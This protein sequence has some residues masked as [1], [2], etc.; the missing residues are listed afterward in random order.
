[1]P[2]TNKFAFTIPDLAWLALLGL[3]LVLMLV[4]PMAGIYQSFNSDHPYP[5]AFLKFMLLAPMG[6][7]LAARIRSGQWKKPTYL[8]GRA[9]VWGFLGMMIALAFQLFSG[10]AAAAAERGFLPRSTSALLNAFIISTA[11]N[12][13]FAP[14]MMAFHR[15]TDTWFDLKTGGTPRPTV[16][17]VAAAVAWDNF[18]SFVVLKTIPFFW[19]PAHTLTF[20]LPGEYRVLMAAMLSMALG[21]LL[22]FAKPRA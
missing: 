10:G 15:L 19:I 22:A 12:V 14:G 9:L 5:A 8:L 17:A 3:I 21:L 18:I 13:L 16:R 2:P 20:L 1:M 4:P 7:M 6:E 11:M